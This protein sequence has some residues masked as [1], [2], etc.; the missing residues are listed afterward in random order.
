MQLKITTD[1]AIRTILYLAAHKTDIV[2]SS[3]VAQTM[4]IPRKYLLQIGAVLKREGLIDTYPGKKRRIQ[5][6]KKG[7]GNFTL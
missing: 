2:S 4:G 1:Y 5:F 3:E 7:K 6:G